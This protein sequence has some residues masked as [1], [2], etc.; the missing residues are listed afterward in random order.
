MFFKSAPIK[1][2]SKTHKMNLK[3]E[4]KRVFILILTGATLAFAF[5]YYLY[6]NADRYLA[7][8]DIS[9]DKIILMLILTLIQQILNG[10]VNVQMFRILGVQLAH[11]DGFYIASASTLANQLPV[12]GGIFMR[13]AY[14][15]YKYNLSY[16]RYFSATSALFFL[17]IASYGFLGEAILL[18]WKF[19]R[20]MFIEPLLFLGFGLMTVC[21][22]LIFTLP[23]FAPR[24]SFLDKWL[25][26]ALEGW[27]ILSKYPALI[28]KIL[29]LQT[30]LTAFLAVEYLLAFQMLSQDITF[31]QSMLFSSASVLTQ[32]VSLAPGGL[33]VREAIVSGV[34]SALGFDLSVSAAAMGL[35][36]LISTSMILLTGCVSAVLLGRQISEMQKNESSLNQSDE[37]SNSS[38]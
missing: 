7:L 28:F 24:I 4:N 12:S 29:A 34:A 1:Y 17:T 36:R 13:G 21:G 22:L 8:L 18:Y 2:G 11:K 19:F 35:D 31:S 9:P 33:G 20:N 38:L 6:I 10:E 23:F 15:K 30:I 16:A 14:L 27:K 25:H 5:F 3:F 26:Q 32:L 37:A